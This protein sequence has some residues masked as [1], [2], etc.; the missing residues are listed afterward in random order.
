MTSPVV[1]VLGK[2]QRDQDVAVRRAAV[3]ALARTGVANAAEPLIAALKDTDDAVRHNAVFALATLCNAT[4]FDRSEG[5]TIGRSYDLRGPLQGAER[6]IDQALCATLQDGDPA[7]RERAAVALGQFSWQHLPRDLALLR[8]TALRE[9]VKDDLIAVRI[10][11]YR[12]LYRLSWRTLKDDDPQRD[13]LRTEAVEL[14]AKALE[15]EDGTVRYR[16]ADALRGFHSAKAVS[17][18]VRTL[19]HDYQPVRLAAA[20]ALHAMAERHAGVWGD[21]AS[22]TA[23][24]QA[25]DEIG[26]RASIAA[27]TAAL[28]DRDS[29]VRCAVAEALS[30]VGRPVIAALQEGKRCQEPLLARQ[31]QFCRLVTWDDRNEL[32]TE[33]WFTTY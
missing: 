32:P 16:A 25:L 30:A 2:V 11:A 17:P 21:E 15:H 19:Q 31:G 27:L 23:A 28:G 9:A 1:E 18:L 7:M 22:R 29:G 8:E 5:G 4:P 33:A 26:D 24:A 6:A 14:L 20:Q 10:Y 12:A 13:V 3:Q